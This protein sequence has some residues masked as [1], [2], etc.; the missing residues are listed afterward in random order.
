[1]DPLSKLLSGVRAE[2]SIVT[3]AV[4]PAPWIIRFADH[5]PL[6]MVTVMRGGGTLLLPGGG[7]R[8]LVVGDTA[9][10]RGPGEFRLVSSD[11]GNG[12]AA[13]P[14]VRDTAPTEYEIACFHSDSECSGQELTGIRWGSE[15]DATALMVGAYRTSTR[16]HERLLR[17]LP[18]VVVISEDFQ[19]CGWYESAAAAAVGQSAGS[20]AMMDRLFDWSLVC[21]L[22]NWFEQA[23][24]EAPTWFRG[25][26]DPIVGPALH[27]IHTDPGAP[28]TVASLAA[29]AG[30]SRSL[31]AKRFTAVLGRPPLNYLTE[32]RMEEAEELLT[33]TDL[34]IAQIAKAVGYADPFGFSAAFKRHRG[35]SPT[36][37]RATAA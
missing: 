14:G 24:P 7:S 1:M 10:V 29:E 27:A 35:Q 4:M 15:A 22:R 16:R 12:A 5:A 21:T 11:V 2:G 13:R 3:H 8:P 28:W 26:S 31:F 30:V 18:P 25:L 23:G 37:F 34:T 9:L 32:S 33:D 17:A 36:A 20:Q 19:T 6:T